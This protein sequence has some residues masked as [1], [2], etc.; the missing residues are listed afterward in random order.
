MSD[1]SGHDNESLVQGAI[2]YLEKRFAVEDV[3]KDF[4][5]FDPTN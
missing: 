4:V 2:C 3:F 1:L 5:I